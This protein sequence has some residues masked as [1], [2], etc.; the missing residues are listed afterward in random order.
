MWKGTERR[1]RK[2]ESF[3][4]VIL[5]PA[6][7]LTARCCGC[8]TFTWLQKASGWN[9]GRKKSLKK[10]PPRIIRV[11]QPSCLR[12]VYPYTLDPFSVRPLPQL[13]EK[14]LVC[15]LEVNLMVHQGW[16]PCW[17]M[18]SW[19]RRTPGIPVPH[20]EGSDY[21]Q[22]NDAE[23]GRGVEWKAENTTCTIVCLLL[24]DLCLQPTFI[25]TSGVFL[26]TEGLLVL[27]NS[28]TIGIQVLMNGLLF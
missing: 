9:Y 2:G 18:L 14:L 13:F 28:P 15:V 10:H 24:S 3:L 22:V 5:S 7:P 26:H 21:F 19:C 12:K 16:S 25:V 4:Q 8:P 6:A 27:E 11:W 1:Q 23:L 20:L 17:G